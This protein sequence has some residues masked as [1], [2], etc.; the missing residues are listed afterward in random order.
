MLAADEEAGRPY[1][2]MEL[3]PGET[4]ED[5]QLGRALWRWLRPAG[6]AQDGARTD[7][8]RATRIRWVASGTDGPW[9][10]EAYLAPAGMPLSA[11][12]PQEPR[13]S[14]A[15]VR[16]L[17]D[18]LA[19]ELDAACHD[20]TLP[21]MLTIDQVWILPDGLVQLLD[22]PIQGASEDVDSTATTCERDA[23]ND[24]LRALDF[25]SRVAVT[26]LEGVDRPTADTGDAIRVPLPVHASR[27]LDGLL[28]REGPYAAV[29]EFR[30]DLESI[31]SRPTEV[32]RRLRAGHLA[33][34]A[35]L[36]NV[37]FGGFLLLLL[38]VP[39]R[40]LFADSMAEDFNGAVTLAAIA[41]NFSFWVV[42]SF[43]SSGGYAFTRGSIALCQADG[44][45]A[46]NLQC[47]LRALL[48]WTPIAG[49]Y[50]LSI[51]VARWQPAFA[52]LYFT[53]FGIGTALLPLYV[54]LALVNPKRGLHDWIVGTYLVPR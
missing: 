36:V 9:Q 31:R 5:L 17:L 15:E 54:V 1:I 47:G 41:V 14:W 25:L 16:P 18:E 43:L 53:L 21:R 23:D 13:L 48:V 42:W 46:T 39:L 29:A 4:L 28:N 38:I 20:G 12:A 2:V 34:T 52:A 45:R 51:L 27:V 32:S 30:H 22:A 44:R 26:A 37:P 10:W 40:L 7:V 33:L 49:I 6:A 8:N 11:L 19:E 3:M 24:Q 50:A 35:L